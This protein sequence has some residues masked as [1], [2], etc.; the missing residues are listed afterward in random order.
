MLFT[1]ESTISQD[2]IAASLLMKDHSVLPR[3]LETVPSIF[4][5]VHST[6]FR[7]SFDTTSSNHPGFIPSIFPNRITFS[8]AKNP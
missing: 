8:D 6:K 4:L 7:V 3:V 1:A 5:A 2:F